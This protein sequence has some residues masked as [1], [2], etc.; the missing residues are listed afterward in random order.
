M[1]VTNRLELKGQKFGKL[2][3]TDIDTL[4]K[5]RHVYWTCICDCGKKVSVRGN[6]LKN[7]NTTSCGCTH[8]EKTREANTKSFGSSTKNN[9]WVSFKNRAKVRNHKITITFKE[10]HLLGKENCFY[11]GSPPSNIIKSKYNNGDF[12][13]NG[14]DRIDSSL[15]YESSNCVPCCKIC[16]RAK[17][18]MTER[19][20][21]E[22]IKKVYFSLLNNKRF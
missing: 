17:S 2:L 11:C 21:T 16:N 14:I 12:I 3:V 6:N 19:K 18:D 7:G 9:A 13:Y 1:K 8:K 4:K 10:W 5:N 22:W 15:G 20:F